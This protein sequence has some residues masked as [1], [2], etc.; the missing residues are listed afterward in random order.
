MAK[1]KDLPRELMELAKLR[2]SQQ[3][4]LTCPDPSNFPI[5]K[6]EC[7]ITSLFSFRET[8]EYKLDQDF[9]YKV[10]RFTDDIYLSIKQSPAYPKYNDIFDSSKIDKQI[11]EV[12]FYEKYWM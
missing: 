8:P 12:Q 6:Y 9:W 5:Q 7:G 2:Y 11:S 4:K 10:A 3:Y 1:L